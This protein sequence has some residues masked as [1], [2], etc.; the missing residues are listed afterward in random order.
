MLNQVP[1]TNCQ[2]TNFLRAFRT[3]PQASGLGLILDTD[4]TEP[5]ATA[6]IGKLQAWNRF[7]LAHLELSTR[8]TP[9]NATRLAES[10]GSGKRKDGKKAAAGQGRPRKRAMNEAQ[11]LFGSNF[12]VT[13]SCLACGS[14]TSREDD[15][16]VIE[17]ESPAAI[18]ELDDDALAKYSFAAFLRD[19]VCREHFAKSFCKHEGCKDYRTARHTRRVLELP[20]VLALNCNTD[21]PAERAFWHR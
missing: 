16:M 15:K 6:M 3:I 9:V 2:A 1:G 20:D 19:S 4:V 10:R 12:T 13:S 8:E 17:L 11:Y 14:K 5:D 18:A 7:M 21:K